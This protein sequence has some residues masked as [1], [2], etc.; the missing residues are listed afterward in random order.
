MSVRLMLLP[1]AVLALAGL[2]AGAC[3]A[4]APSAPP[5]AAKAPASTTAP[6]KPGLAARA[7]SD[8]SAGEFYRGKTIRMVVAFP[9]GGGLDTVSRLLTKHMRRYIPGDP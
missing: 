5:G 9:A 8:Q 1:V 2:L 7:A 6:A 4:A 3:A